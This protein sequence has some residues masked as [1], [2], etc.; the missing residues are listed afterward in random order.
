[1]N[2]TTTTTTTAAATTKAGMRRIKT[3][4][5]P[6]KR[7]SLRSLGSLSASFLALNLIVAKQEKTFYPHVRFY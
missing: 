1:M 6:L 2:A 3:K 7:N 4:S 5:K